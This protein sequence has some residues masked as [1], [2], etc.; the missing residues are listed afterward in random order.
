MCNPF[1]GLGLTGGILDVGGL[2]DCLNGIATGKAEESILDQYS[3]VRSKLYRDFTDP[4]S[5]AN[6]RRLC[7]RDPDKIL[8][9][10]TFLQMINESKHNP[11]VA[12]QLSEG[13]KGLG[14]DFTQYYK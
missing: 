2:Y 3:D 13:S 1:G 8:E 9:E 12:A 10:D 11:E 4:V 7:K 14:H 6:M 5:T